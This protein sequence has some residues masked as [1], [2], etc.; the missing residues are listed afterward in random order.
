MSRSNSSAR[1]VSSR[2]RLCVQK[3]EAMREPRVIGVDVVQA[4][5]GIDDHVAGRQL[6]RMRAVGVLDDQLAAVVVLRRGQRTAC[7]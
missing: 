5:A 1:W 6:H 3:N 4:G 7:S 2:I